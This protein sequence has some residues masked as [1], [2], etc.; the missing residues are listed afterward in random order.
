MKLKTAFTF[1]E[2]LIV[3][4]I[5]AFVSLAAIHALKPA[6]QIESK[7]VKTKYKTVYK[8]LNSVAYDIVYQD[9]T[10]PFKLSAQDITDGKS[11]F[12]KLCNGFVDYINTS[13]THCDEPA[14]NNN[15]GR[16]TS[17]TTDFRNITPH[18][19]TTTNVRFYFSGLMSGNAYGQAIEYFMIYADFN[20]NDNRPHTIQYQQNSDRLPSVYAFAMTPKGYVVPIG[21]AEYSTRVLDA[22]VG[23]REN[24]NIVGFSNAYSYRKAKHKAWGCYGT[25][26]GIPEFKKNIAATYTDYIRAD[27]V[28]NKGSQLYQFLQSA[29]FPA[30][31]ND[32]IIPQCRAEALRT[33]YDNCKVY[34]DTKH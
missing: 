20:E 13:S 15:I 9:D 8:T 28:V 11:N 10:N 1:V 29:N 12:S 6:R 14:L 31:Y 25:G 4:T 24:R 21:L 3:V 19:T 17:E 23:Y 30:T 2:L 32:D 27:L 5:I 26:D 18:I 7:A 16:M 22:Q 34:V 33:V